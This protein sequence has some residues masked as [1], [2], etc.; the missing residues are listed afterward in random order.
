MTPTLTDLPDVLP[1]V[2][3]VDADGALVLQVTHPADGRTPPKALHLGPGS[4]GHCLSE[5]WVGH[6]LVCVLDGLFIVTW[7]V[8]E[9]CKRDH[10][11]LQ[12]TQKM[13]CGSWRH[14][15]KTENVVVGVV[16]RTV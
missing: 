1:F 12:P 4:A 5:A 15:E 13:L 3:P 8:Q 2:G 16:V 9:A 6:Q 10:C 14:S 11:S 7:W